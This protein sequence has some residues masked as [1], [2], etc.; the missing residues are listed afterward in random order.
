M[1]QISAEDWRPGFFPALFK[2]LGHPGLQTNEIIDL[3]SKSY[4]LSVN[5]G[6]KV[7]EPENS[8]S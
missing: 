2:S 7:S 1:L 5:S 6:F 4:V 3:V 8:V